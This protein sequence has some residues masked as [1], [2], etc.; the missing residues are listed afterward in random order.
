ML[1]QQQLAVVPANKRKEIEIEFFSFLNENF[2]SKTKR[3][4]DGWV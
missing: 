1:G 4:I 3:S 2:W